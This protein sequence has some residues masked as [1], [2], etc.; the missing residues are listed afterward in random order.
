MQIFNLNTQIFY[1][2]HGNQSISK[3]PIYFGFH[4]TNHLAPGIWRLRASYDSHTSTSTKIDVSFPGDY[5][6]LHQQVCILVLN[7]I[8]FSYLIC[9]VK[10]LCILD[11]VFVWY[12]FIYNCYYSRSLFSVLTLIFR[13]YFRTK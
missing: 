2:K 11:I 7:K 5:S 4:D 10:G 6:E 1:C 3:C 9:H 8:I 13:W 12:F